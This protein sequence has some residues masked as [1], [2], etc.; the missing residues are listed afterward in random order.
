MGAGLGDST[1]LITDGRFSGASRGFIVGHIVPEARLG[2]PIAM[3][4]DGDCIII[5]S[6]NR[7]IDWLVSDAEHARRREVWN[8]SGKAELKEKRGILFKYAR[9]VAPANVGAYTD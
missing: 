3:V 2:G 6:Q 8:A 7:K 4:E 5:D 1:A 9:D